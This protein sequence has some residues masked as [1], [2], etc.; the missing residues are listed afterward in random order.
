MKKQPNK[1]KGDKKMSQ[2]NYYVSARVELSGG[3]KV[4]GIIANNLETDEKMIIT[5]KD[6]EKQD[7]KQLDKDWYGDRSVH[8]E[9]PVFVEAEG[10]QKEYKS[11]LA[12][13]AWKQEV[14]MNVAVYKKLSKRSFKNEVL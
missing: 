1:K 9:A 5:S 11:C 3:Q 2:Y 13:T 6:I 14:M 12:V 7:V 4:T 10:L 8:T